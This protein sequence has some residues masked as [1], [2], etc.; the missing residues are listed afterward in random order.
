MQCSKRVGYLAYPLLI[1]GFC[2]ASFSQAQTSSTSPEQSTATPATDDSQ[3]Q[4]PPDSSSAQPQTKYPDAQDRAR[5]AREAQERVRARRAAR[6]QAAIKDTYSHKYDIY[7]GY[8]YL[9]MRPGHNLQHAT[10]YGWNAGFTDY[11]RPKLGV[12]V[13]LRGYYTNAYVGNN[14]YA[15]FKPFISNYAVLAGPQYYLRQRKSYAVS[16]QVLAGVT[17][18]LFYA[19]SAKLSGTFVGLYPNQTR[20]TAVAAVPVD[21][22]LGPGLALRISP[23]YNLTTWGGDIQHNLGFTTGLNYRFGRH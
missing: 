18:N 11:L 21:V 15:L 4:A 5:L 8:A 16:G 22:N 23:T 1:L 20:F 17:R 7:F 12:T 3:Q 10:E 2:V 13:D 14:P 9:R 19:N 6:T